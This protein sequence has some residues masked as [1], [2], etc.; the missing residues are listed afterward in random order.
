MS[1][2]IS[3]GRAGGILRILSCAAV[4]AFWL[5]CGDKDTKGKPAPVTDTTETTV[6]SAPETL[7]ANA[8]DTMVTYTSD[9]ASTS[10][11]ETTAISAPQTTAASAARPATLPPVT[12]EDGF[13][14]VFV[15]G[16]AF[17]MGC[18]ARP[19]EYCE[20]DE[21]PA[22]IVVL[23]D[24]YIGKYEVTQGLWESVMGG[25]PSHFKGND[26]LPVENIDGQRDEIMK[27]IEKLNAKTGKKY[28]LPTE[29]E[30]EYAARGGNRSKGYKY[31]GS[32]TLEDVA[33]YDRDSC[34]GKSC[35][36]CC[37][38]NSGG[39]THT[40][41][42]KQPNELGIHDM[43]GNVRECVSDIYGEYSFNVQTDPTKPAKIESDFGQQVTRGGGFYDYAA[44][45]R[46][47]HR[48]FDP[49]GWRF[50]VLG[51]RLAHSAPKNT[52]SAPAANR[53]RKL[54]NA[55]GEAWTVEYYG[56]AVEYNAAGVIFRADGSFAAIEHHGNDT[57]R[58]GTMG[59]LYWEVKKTG[60][61]HT[62][63]NKTMK[64]SSGARTITVPYTVTVSDGKKLLCFDTD[65]SVV[66][67][68][69]TVFYEMGLDN[70][71]CAEGPG[72]SYSLKTV[73][74]EK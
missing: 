15:E 70:R 33:W 2:T 7:A 32:N 19:D 42:T 54:V 31:S 28:R 18:A 1:R 26:S 65:P 47:S 23:S 20:A 71:S 60:T 66:S 5:S 67:V 38:G 43:S 34:G 22:H 14:M 35:S 52:G 68:E 45:C 36:P 4:A 55:R 13:D 6:T 11:P 58:Y 16:G 29:S 44:Q 10:T 21:R 9:T 40:V 69:D 53:D 17:V 72:R 64:L 12:S 62:V 25:N 30:W 50:W 24:F 48:S 59:H 73:V 49:P 37:G 41:G 8:A 27:F 61:W 57:W 3:G 46:V 39:K 51:F 74:V 63:G 56:N